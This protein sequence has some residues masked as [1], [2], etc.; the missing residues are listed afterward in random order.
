MWISIARVD[1]GSRA[2]T[3]SRLAAVTPSSTDHLP[4]SRPERRKHD[5]MTEPA[6]QSIRSHPRTEQY[7]AMLP[8]RR[9]FRLTGGAPDS[10]C[11]RAML[12]VWVEELNGA[13]VPVTTDSSNEETDQELSFEKRWDSLQNKDNITFCP[14][15]RPP[16]WDDVNGRCLRVK[17]EKKTGF[18]PSIVIK[19]P[20]KAWSPSPVRHR[21]PAPPTSGR[22]RALTQ[23]MSRPSTDGSSLNMGGFSKQLRDVFSDHFL[24]V[25]LQKIS[26]PD[27]LE[28]EYPSTLVEAQLIESAQQL[29]S[30]S[31]VKQS[32]FILDVLE[33]HLPTPHAT[34]ESSSTSDVAQHPCAISNEVQQSNFT[35]N[36]TEHAHSTLQEAQ[37]SFTSNVTQP[38]F[39]SRYVTQQSSLTSDIA[40]QLSSSTYM[41]QQSSSKSCVIRNYSSTPDVI[42][43]PFTTLNGS[44]SP[45]ST[46]DQQPPITHNVSQ[47]SCLR[48]ND[49]HMW[50]SSDS[51]LCE[52]FTF[53]DINRRYDGVK[54]HHGPPGEPHLRTCRASRL[55]TTISER[56]TG[57]KEYHA[58][59]KG[60]E[61]GSSLSATP[62]PCRH[63]G[64][65]R[66]TTTPYASS[67][68]GTCREASTIRIADLPQ[69][70]HWVEFENDPTKRGTPIVV[71]PRKIASSSLIKDD[72]SS[73]G[74]IPLQRTPPNS[75]PY[76]ITPV[77]QRSSSIK[78]GSYSGR[79]IRTYS[80]RGCRTSKRVISS[81]S[82][83]MSA[84]DYGR[85][86]ESQPPMYSKAAM[87]MQSGPGLFEETPCKS[88]MEYPHEEK[89]PHSERL[90]AKPS[91]EEPTAP[92]RVGS[93]RLPRLPAVLLRR[94]SSLSSPHEKSSEVPFQRL[95]EQR[96]GSFRKIVGALARSFRRKSNTAN[97]PG[98]T[99]NQSRSTN[100]SVA[101]HTN[102]KQTPQAPRLPR[103]AARQSYIISH[104]CERPVS[105]V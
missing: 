78:A 73:S 83:R 95:T 32:S 100:Q 64:S 101:V 31:E 89:R 12:P 99:A 96:P 86:S 4:S 8:G 59:S 38:H 94:S 3:G 21:L 35:S 19:E 45:S 36:E 25:P 44:H 75:P 77:H 55:P 93:M 30:T 50:L 65:L 41:V 68:T 5:Q 105:Y 67:D 84:S 11:G 72:T 66:I 24:K 60:D 9:S 56:W 17:K 104:D 26:S 22:P 97:K 43:Q 20:D 71:A 62:S 61:K 33:Q 82:R 103:R 63:T 69:R 88:E 46:M 15:Q 28:S 85:L 90:K 102:D 76:M 80:Q 29:S 27:T 92:R 34:Q 74:E 37:S 98:T 23:R 51:F 14:T 7:G 57:S 87:T 70:K 40:H 79:L 18:C 49:C 52:D 16:G 53:S 54:E 13:S 47:K 2:V 6:V 10:G 42:Q 48:Y 91:L 81:V 39:S 58:T 1:V